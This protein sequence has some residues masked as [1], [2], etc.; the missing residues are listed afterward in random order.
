M[1]FASEKAAGKN[2][3]RRKEVDSFKYLGVITIESNE[4]NNSEVDKQ[5]VKP[6]IG[7]KNILKNKASKLITKY[8]AETMSLRQEEQKKL[9]ISERTIM[10]NIKVK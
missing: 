9:S 5:Q 6:T 10:R 7:T 3:H 8:A 1:N 4:Q 2:L